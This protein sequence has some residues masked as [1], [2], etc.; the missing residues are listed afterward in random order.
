MALFAFTLSRPQQDLYLVPCYLSS[1]I[2][3]LLYYNANVKFIIKAK[4]SKTIL[5]H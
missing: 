3:V 2:V 4:G 1:S 5:N